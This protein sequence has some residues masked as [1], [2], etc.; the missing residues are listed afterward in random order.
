MKKAF[1]I[2]PILLLISL[3]GCEKEEGER[4]TDQISFCY[5]NL[6]SLIGKS[7]DYI[8]RVSPGVFQKDYSS[9]TDYTCYLYSGLPEMG[10][11]YIFYIFTF[12]DDNEYC[13]CIYITFPS[14]GL[15]TLKKMMAM[16]ETEGLKYTYKVKRFDAN[17][18]TSDIS[19]FETYNDLWSYIDNSDIDEYD[20]DYVYGKSLYRNK[21]NIEIGGS[22]EDDFIT[23]VYIN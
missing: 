12:L 5:T 9:G 19:T 23:S 6:S 15:N 16:A 10:D 17:D 8:D 14:N 18:D 1:L 13:Q 22:W 3:V 20:L 21:F 2:I 11:I 4:N 7:I